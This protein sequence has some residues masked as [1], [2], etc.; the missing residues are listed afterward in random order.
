MKEKTKTKKPTVYLEVYYSN[1][2]EV[3]FDKE[4]NDFISLG[5]NGCPMGSSGLS[6]ADAITDLFT[7]TN[8]N[9]FTEFEAN[10]E[11]SNNIFVGYHQD[12]EEEDRIG[13]PLEEDNELN[14]G[15]KRLKYYQIKRNEAGRLV[16]N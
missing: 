8:Y 13:I 15:W 3:Y 9:C 7:R 10:G 2:Y 12:V 16:W 11:N 4:E 1:R 14:K 6:V 5:I